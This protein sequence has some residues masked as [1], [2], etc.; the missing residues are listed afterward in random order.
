MSR[1]KAPFPYFGGKQ[2]IAS[3]VWQALGDISAY[4]EP[5]AGSLAVL[6]GRPESFAG[7]ETVND[8]DGL[9]CNFWRALKAKPHLVAQHAD[10][11][12]NEN[13]LHAR[14]AWLVG[15]KDSL[16]ARLE[17][18]P[19]YYDAKVAGWWVWGMA[20]WIGSDF[21]SGKGP[22]QIV[23]SNG[24]RQLIHLGNAGQGVQRQ[25]VHLC[26]TG[27]GVQRKRVHLGNAGQ[28]EAGLG[29]Q[30]LLAW[31]EALARRLARVRICCGDWTR[32]C[33]GRT[34]DALSHFFIAGLP[35]GIF[36]DPPYSSEADREMGC[37]RVDDGDVAHA[38]REWALRHG[39]DRRLRIV[40][41]GYDGEHQMPKRWRCVAWKSKG[42]MSNQA[43]G[44]SRAKDNCHRERLWLSPYCLDVTEHLPAFARA[45]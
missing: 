21:C 34:G 38:V 36:L 2:R 30:G 39:D 13:D 19:H 20:C 14:H 28:G 31:M 24:D 37:Y 16:Q 40:F 45:A 22:W 42:G 32:I 11:P 5:F 10:W 8:A 23:A 44:D 4:I 17:G 6:L 9:I 3:I 41:A 25:R 7:V 29:E 1:Y 33:G 15:K 35:C 12:V 27:N 26:N 43:K 18:N